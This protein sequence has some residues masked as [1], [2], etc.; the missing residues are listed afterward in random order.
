[1]SGYGRR[2]GRN[3]N[4]IN[5]CVKYTIFFF[6]FVFWLLG[7]IF[8]GVGLYAFF[9]KWKGTGYSLVLNAEQMI[10]DISIIMLIVGFVM[11]TVSFAGCVGALRENSCLLKF[12][13]AC[14]LLFFIAELALATLGFVFPQK[15]TGILEKHLTSKLI[16]FYREDPDLQNIIDF[17]QQEFKCCGLSQSG[18]LDWSQNEYFN[19]TKTNPSVE[20]CAVP[21]SCCRN[22]A[23][24]NTGL[25]N[26]MCG[27]EAQQLTELEAAKKIHISGCISIIEMWVYGNLYIIAGIATV[28]AFAQLFV[29]FLARTLEGQIQRQKSLWMR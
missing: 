27:Y 18:Y 13:S 23:D 26:V 6:N 10:L 5:V 14:L 21:F 15:V 2:R 16:E 7:G 9:E 12:Y 8:V 19:C 29:I 1:M 11:F 17:T 3:I 28:V 4:H 25:I 24:I 20:R 22:P